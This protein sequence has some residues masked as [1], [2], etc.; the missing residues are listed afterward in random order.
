MPAEDEAALTKTL[1]EGPTNKGL[2]NT[3]SV[4]ALWTR[5]LLG[6]TPMAAALVHASGREQWTQEFLV[7]T[8]FPT[9]F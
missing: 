4:E 6:R 3:E 7:I 1:L 5:F 9:S 8:D 2:A